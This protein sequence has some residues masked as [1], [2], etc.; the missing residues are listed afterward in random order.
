VPLK[1]SVLRAVWACARE[2]NVSREELHEAIWAGW[3][4]QSV[5]ELTDA[6]ACQLLDGLRGKR[7]STKTGADYH[8]RQAMGTHGRR[9]ALA[10][11]TYLA[12]QTEKDLAWRIAG[13]LGWCLDAYNCFVERQL[14]KTGGIVT[15][16]D[17]NR[18]M[19]ALKAIQR[20]QAQQLGK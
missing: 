14:G 12:N 20:R 16:A 1:P 8:R 17:Y 3:R 19:W 9:D 4:K 11:P 18:V 2:R 5:N 15:M 7:R 10:D 6:E 13:N